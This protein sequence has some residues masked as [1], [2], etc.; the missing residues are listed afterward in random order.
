MPD[1]LDQL[2][3]ESLG[4]LV[5]VDVP[6]L[7]RR[8]RRRRRARRGA[9]VGGT[10]LILLLLAAAVVVIPRGDDASQHVVTRPDDGVGFVVEGA[11]VGRWMQG[12]AP[13][14][15]PRVAVF[16]DRLDDGRVL[17]WGGVDAQQA[18]QGGA[19]GLLHFQ[20]DGA[21]YDVRSDTWESIPSVPLPG[22]HR[23]IGPSGA[24]FFDAQVEGDTF[25]IVGRS[26]GGVLDAAVYDITEQTWSVAPAQE[27]LDGYGVDIAWDGTTLVLVRTGRGYLGEAFET[28]GP[29]TRRWSPGD[30][31]WTDGAAPPLGGRSFATTAYA[32]GELALFGG[33]TT[34]LDQPGTVADETTPDPGAVRDGAIY[35]IAAD[36]WTAIPAP[37]P[38][39]G[40][41]HALT[42]RAGE[43]LVGG[44]ASGRSI[45]TSRYSALAAY[46]P[47]TGTWR[48]LASSP[49]IDSHEVQTRPTVVGGGLPQGEPPLVVAEGVSGFSG[50]H[51]WYLLGDAW[52]QVPF[53]ALVAGDDLVVALTNLGDTSTVSHGGRAELAVRRSPGRWQ[54]GLTAPFSGRWEAGVVTSDGR[55][56]AISEAPAAPEDADQQTWLFDPEG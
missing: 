2:V 1:R 43:L 35:D 3:T 28:P 53:P 25:A 27:D 47:I 30:A 17:V 41:A 13:P 38:S 20:P 6:A 37:P 54:P 11:P 49:D 45:G 34:S 32:S 15:S 50:E 51:P 16:A 22:G 5:P 36:R 24:M 23:I 14:L 33:T 55:L 56:V 19:A 7:G 29:F 10:A 9:L 39:I 4:D 40:D 12:A 18:A 44:D 48:T 8:A 26:D 52:E 21:I 42:W 46:D 31:E